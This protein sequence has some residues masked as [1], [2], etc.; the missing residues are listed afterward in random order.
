M[1]LDLGLH[2]F[3]LCHSF[4]FS[5]P[6]TALP[7]LICSFSI[8]SSRLINS[9]TRLPIHS[10]IKQ[11]D[12]KSGRMWYLQNF[13]MHHAYLRLL[14]AAAPCFLWVG[15]MSAES[16]R[17]KNFFPPVCGPQV[18]WC[19][20]ATHGEVCLRELW[21][22]GA[23]CFL[24]CL[25]GSFSKKKKGGG[26]LSPTNLKIVKS[27][28][29]VLHFFGYVDSAVNST[30]QKYISIGIRA[31]ISSGFKPV[32]SSLNKSSRGEVAEQKY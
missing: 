18:W 30:S 6:A 13:L 32:L 23:L 11:V 22:E 1:L 4:S 9:T 5:M 7:K 17:K 10:I 14:L 25:K 16:D 31:A 12:G 19:H 28:G 29:Q 24:L 20:P 15:G 26:D 21:V 2:F 8:H 3:F 27:A